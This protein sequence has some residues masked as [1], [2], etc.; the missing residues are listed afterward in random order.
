MEHDVARRILGNGTN[1]ILS[2]DLGTFLHR[3]G[4]KVAIDGDVV[5]VTDKLSA[6]EK[7]YYFIK[8]KQGQ[9]FTELISEIATIL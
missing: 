3:N 9:K 2:R 6:D 1:H 8:A 4:G 7:P 5:S